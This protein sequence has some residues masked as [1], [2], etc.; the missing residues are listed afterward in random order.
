M[1]KADLESLIL[2]SFQNDNID[3]FYIM[4]FLF[5]ILS[6]DWEFGFGNFDYFLNTEAPQLSLIQEEREYL[7]TQ[8]LLSDQPLFSDEA[9]FS[10]FISRNTLFFPS[11]AAPSA[12]AQKLAE[13][14]VP[15]SE[16]VEFKASNFIYKDGRAVPL[17]ADIKKDR[18]RQYFVLL[19][20]K[21]IRIF[22]KS[23]LQYKDKRQVSPDTEIIK[24]GTSFFAKNPDGTAGDQVFTVTAL[25]QAKLKYKNGNLVS[26]D[27]KIIEEGREYFVQNEDGTKDQVFT[28]TALN[29]KRLLPSRFRYK[30]GGEISCDAEIIK[31]GRKY[32]VQSDGEKIPVITVEA[33][34]KRKL[35]Y[36][37]GEAVSSEAKI[38]KKG[39][40]YFVENEDGIKDQVRTVAA[41]RHAQ[42][43][44]LN[45][46]P[47]SP[48]AKIIE[49]RH[50]YFVENKDEKRD[51]VFTISA[52]RQ[53]QLKYLNGKPVSPGAK[54]EK[55]GRNYF[56]QNPDGSSDQVV[57]A[58]GFQRRKLKYPDGKTVSPDADKFPKTDNPLLS[59]ENA[60]PETGGLSLP[61]APS[62]PPLPS[63]KNAVDYLATEDSL[64]P[65]TFDK[66][67]ESD[68]PFLNEVEID[69]FPSLLPTNEHSLGFAS[70]LPEEPCFLK[71]F[72]LFSPDKRSADQEGSTSSLQPIKKIKTI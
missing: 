1:K 54:I 32:F 52:L 53:A 41:L 5:N 27:A 42:L 13:T 31:E 35:K 33:F 45:G 19:N 34:Q 14:R 71:T 18:G 25:R 10:Y 66:G 37:D 29:K 70:P 20:G 46:E 8:Q 55:V 58:S 26:P 47:V 39:R 49:E 12:R 50:K 30:D 60:F 51:Q 69:V 9:L 23:G 67:D 44:Y 22:S 15:V 2:K 4:K 36:P 43:K 72:S 65:F 21:K 16:S 38:I 57:T 28:V 24:K 63:N 64:P 17:D 68:D 3:H 40:E 7:L 11:L 61:L 59:F 48:D 6:D 56:V 62:L